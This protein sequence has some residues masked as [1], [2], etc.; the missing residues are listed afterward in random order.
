MCFFLQFMRTFV[1][2]AERLQ[3]YI[4]GGLAK[5]LQYY[6]ITGGGV[7]QKITVPPHPETENQ[8]P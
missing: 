3:Y 2:A 7:A 4:G 6:N 1:I 5:R 8:N